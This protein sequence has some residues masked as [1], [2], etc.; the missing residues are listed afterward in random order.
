MFCLLWDRA[1]IPLEFWSY[2]AAARYLETRCT[3]RDAAPNEA[4]LRKWTRRLGLIQ[5]H[6]SVVTDFNPRT[7]I[8]EKG[9][10]LGALAMHG[11]P[12]GPDE[13][14]ENHNIA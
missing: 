11:I 12:Y 14:S 5:A 10:N 4:T 1:S 8:P 9:F 13:A 6:P 7:G 2:P 3:V